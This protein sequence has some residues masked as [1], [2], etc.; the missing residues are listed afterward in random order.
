M[1]INLFENYPN[2]KINFEE[3]WQSSEWINLETH[4]QLVSKKKFTSFLLHNL[5]IWEKEPTDPI[6]DEYSSVYQRL[7]RSA[8]S[9]NLKLRFI[10]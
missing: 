10:N 2:N 3:K 5:Q 7:N 9:L 6:N 1:E 4:T 8:D